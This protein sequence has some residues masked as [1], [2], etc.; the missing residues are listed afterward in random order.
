MFLS[1]SCYCNTSSDCLSV[2]ECVMHSG[3]ILCEI[4]HSHCV[5]DMFENA[6]CSSFLG[7]FGQ[8]NH[9]RM[10]VCYRS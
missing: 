1:R 10:D 7:G 4:P 2:A 6:H 8:K 3:Y 9:T 5:D